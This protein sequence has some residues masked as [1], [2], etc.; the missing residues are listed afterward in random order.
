MRQYNWPLG[1]GFRA[2]LTS[3]RPPCP[4]RPAVPALIPL[5]L[6]E[7]IRNLDT[8][9]EDG[10]EELAEEMV[11]RRLGLS[12]TVAAQIQRYR[13][14]A[15]RDGSVELDEA[16]SV[17]RLVGR[18]PDAALVFADAGRR[19]ARYATRAQRP[20]LDHGALADRRPQPPAGARAVA[21][22]ARPPSRARSGP[23]PTAARFEMDQPLSIV[24]LPDGSACAFYGAAFNELLRRLADFEGAML[25]CAAAPGA[26]PSAPGTR[27]RRR[28]TSDPLRPE[29]RAALA[30]AGADAWLIFDFHGLNPVAPAPRARAGSTPAGSSCCSG[31]RRAGGG[32]ASDRAAPAGRVPGRVMPTRGGRSCTRRWDDRG[33]AA[34]WPWRSRRRTP[35]PI[36]IG[37][38]HGVVELIRRLGGTVVPSGALVTRFA[39]RWT[40][41]EAED[42][43]QAA[44]ILAAVAREELA[45]AVRAAG[46]GLRGTE[47]QQRVV[48]A[49]RP[50]GSPSTR[51]RSRPSAPTAPTRTTSPAGPGRGAGAGQVVLLDLWAG[52]RRDTVFADQT[53]MGFAGERPPA[54]VT[55]VWETVRRARDAAIA[56]VQEAAKADRPIARVRGRPRR[57]GRDRGGGLRLGFVHRTGHSIDRDLHGSG[58]HLDDYETHDDRRL[59][60][61]VGFSVEP[62]IYLAGEFGIRSEVNVYLGPA[63]PE[64]TPRRAAAGA[65]HGGL[66]GSPSQFLHRAV[67]SAPLLPVCPIVTK[68]DLPAAE[69]WRPSATRYRGVRGRARH[70]DGASTPPFHRAT[71][72]FQRVT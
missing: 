14:A 50:E 56:T 37:C 66:T 60:P 29:L 48:A 26:M 67:I 72:R 40:S 65:D 45:R 25:H 36:W 46:T 13:A 30:E 52:R 27:R 38:P 34:G 70:E 9:V 10:L 12:P 39:S 22:V 57:P 35:C 16:V 17:L 51:R 15:E 33:R 21:R 47:L 55:Q 53:W 42:H 49:A 8:P 43:R 20:A 62:G 71:F 68:H 41:A 28:S 6:L 31:R 24:A 69:G 19:A 54:R 1:A 11:V 3:A 44:E 18:R 61:G 4:P 7:A 5:S 63:G 59:L 64:V 32:G 23:A 58:P 2:R